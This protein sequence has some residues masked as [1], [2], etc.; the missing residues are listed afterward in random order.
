MLTDIRKNFR[1]TPIPSSRYDDLYF[2]S[3]AS[4]YFEFTPYS[5]HSIRLDGELWP[6]VSHYF[7]AQK[8]DYRPDI[9]KLIQ[10]AE[11][12]LAAWDIAHNSENVKVVFGH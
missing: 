3:S 1:Q 2:T 10:A 11:T 9:V 12:P 5:L 8:F 6:T 7:Q 4:D